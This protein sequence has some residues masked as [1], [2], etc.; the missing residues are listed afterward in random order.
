RSLRSYLKCSPAG[1]QEAMG[2]DVAEQLDQR[3]DEPRPAGLVR[4]SDAGAVVAVEVLEEENQVAPVWVGLELLRAAV[5]GPST[6]LV[7]QEIRERRATISFAP[8][9]RVISLP[10]PLGPSTRNAS[11]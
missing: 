4:R 5:H 3:C 6:A 10:E 9:K 1:F 11:P 2:I 8:S 7:A